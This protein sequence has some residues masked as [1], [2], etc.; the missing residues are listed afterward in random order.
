[1]EKLDFKKK[2]EKLLEAKEELEKAKLS[3]DEELAKLKAEAEKLE[4]LKENLRK[5]EKSLA[6]KEAESSS[7]L[8][9]V[10]VLANKVSSMPPNKAVEMLVNWPDTDIIEVFKQMDKNAEEDGRPSIT[11]Y[12]LTLF[13]PERR[14]VITNKWLDTDN[15]KL[16]II[17]PEADDSAQDEEQESV[18]SN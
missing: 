7:R 1:M 2:E 15:S 14:S 10:K 17:I 13:N 16:P 4:Q 11:T 18:K 9:Q 5:K 8:E 12:L 3:L 6:E